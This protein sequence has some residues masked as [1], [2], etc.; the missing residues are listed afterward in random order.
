MT[1]DNNFIDWLKSQGFCIIYQRGEGLF[2]GTRLERGELMVMIGHDAVIDKRNI[3][4]FHLYDNGQVRK[5]I[6]VIGEN[7]FFNMVLM[8]ELPTD[9][10]QYESAI[11]GELK[12][13]Q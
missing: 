4:Y 6:D 11:K 10:T 2:K 8:W 7:R 1:D 9:K 5:R 3:S 13:I 12:P